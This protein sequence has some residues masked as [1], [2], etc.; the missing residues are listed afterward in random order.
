MDRVRR[1]I[2][3]KDERSGEK[4]VREGRRNNV[5]GKEG[6]QRK[7]KVGGKYQSTVGCDI[8]NLKNIGEGSEQAITAGKWSLPLSLIV[9]GF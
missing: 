7:E 1:N 9:A 5:R 6:L 4:A 3:W 2:L 8:Q